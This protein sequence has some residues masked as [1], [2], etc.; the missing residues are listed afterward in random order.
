MA[1]GRATRRDAPTKGSSAT[2]RADLMGAR[3][4]DRI[5]ASGQVPR[6]QAGHMTAP[7]LA[8]IQLRALDPQGPSTHDP[9][10][11]KTMHHQMPGPTPSAILSS[12]LYV[13]G[14]G[15]LLM[16]NAPT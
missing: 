14:I 5:R 4:A 1:N 6:K 16:H 10:L 2:Q 12:N 11:G 7:D 3:R 15:V 8:A 13:A 9:K